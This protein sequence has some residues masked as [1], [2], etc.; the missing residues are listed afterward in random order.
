LVYPLLQAFNGLLTVFAIG[1]KQH[2]EHAAFFPK[3]FFLKQGTVG[4]APGSKLRNNGVFPKKGEG[5][6]TCLML[7]LGSSVLAEYQEGTKE[8]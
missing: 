7:M 6:I 4:H 3:V 1:A 5:G 8:Q 2:N